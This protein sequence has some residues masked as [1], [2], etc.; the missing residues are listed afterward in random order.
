MQYMYQ[1]C[2]LVAI[3]AF[4]LRY[5]SSSRRLELYVQ[6]EMYAMRSVMSWL[7]Q[8]TA[9]NAAAGAAVLTCLPGT[10]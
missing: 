5:R 3:M 8:T 2:I 9:A 7:L 4:V 10:R 1:V 6:V